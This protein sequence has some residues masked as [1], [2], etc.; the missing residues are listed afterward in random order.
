MPDMLSYERVQSCHGPQDYARSAQNLIELTRGTRI[1]TAVA[2]F[3]SVVMEKR[4]SQGSNRRTAALRQK[5]S[6][7][8]VKYRQKFRDRGLTTLYC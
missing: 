6:I 4:L 2:A 3:P 1:L 5:R 7:E 8:D